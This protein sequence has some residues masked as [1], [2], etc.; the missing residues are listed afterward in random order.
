MQ[1]LAQSFLRLLWIYAR[2][3]RRVACISAVQAVVFGSA[4]RVFCNKQ[5][6]RWQR[7]GNTLLLA[8]RVQGHLMLLQSCKA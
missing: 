5:Q 1:V 6:Q 3:F 7:F 2:N 4:D 8:C